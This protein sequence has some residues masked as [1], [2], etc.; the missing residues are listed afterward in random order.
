MQKRAVCMTVVNIG[1]LIKG[2]DMDTRKIYPSIPWKA[3]AGFRD[4]TAHKY[5]TLNMEDVYNT[6]ID[7]FPVILKN[8]QM[9]DLQED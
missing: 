5:Q 1:E 3:M 8:I 7:E 6:V 4:V 9:I 2:L